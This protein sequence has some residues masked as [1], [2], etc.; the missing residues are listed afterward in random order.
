[1][2]IGNS[3][4]D[5]MNPVINTNKNTNMNTNM[6]TCNYEKATAKVDEIKVQE[7][8]STGFEQKNRDNQAGQPQTTLE[9]SIHKETNT[10][11]IKIVDK[12]DKTVIAE[13]P[14]EKILDLVADMCKRNGLFI[15]EKR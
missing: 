1:M 6:N 8:E 13:L 2:Q 3:Y 4:L 14:P 10:M 15:D 9:Y 11:M 12:V 7:Q 5:G